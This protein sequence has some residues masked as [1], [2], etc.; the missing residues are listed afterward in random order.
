MK[1]DPEVR[2]QLDKVLK[3]AFEK[4]YC[5]VLD[6]DFPQKIESDD[7]PMAEEPA[8]GMEDVVHHWETS[9]KVLMPFKELH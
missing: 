9:Q 2:H 5:E 3:D 1:N 4:A 8:P 7:V 6:L